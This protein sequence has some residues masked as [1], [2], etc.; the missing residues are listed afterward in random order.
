MTIKQRLNSIRAAI[1][2]ESVSL[3]ELV[4]L[5]EHKKDVMAYGDIV[6]AEW[7]GIDEAEWNNNQKGV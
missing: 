2:A 7:A 4:Y 1:D 5:S 3:G 6:L